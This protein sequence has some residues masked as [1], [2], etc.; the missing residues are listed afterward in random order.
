MLSSVKPKLESHGNSCIQYRFPA[1]TGSLVAVDVR[2]ARVGRALQISLG[3]KL[4]QAF[5]CPTNRTAILSDTSYIELLLPVTRRLSPS[6]SH[7]GWTSKLSISNGNPGIM[8]TTPSLLGRQLRP[9]RLLMLTLI[10]VL[11]SNF[12]NLTMLT[13]AVQ[14]YKLD[15]QC[16][17]VFKLQVIPFQ[18][19]ERGL[20]RIANRDPS[21]HSTPVLG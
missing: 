2:C 11:V 12:E 1:G 3:C 9:D 21:S 19:A 14:L 20:R 6:L 16:S 5:I 7:N 15:G 13:V 17:H 10:A 4:Q 18:P 8:S